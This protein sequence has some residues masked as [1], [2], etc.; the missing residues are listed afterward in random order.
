MAELASPWL[1]GWTAALAL[2]LTPTLF[3]LAALLERSGPIRL[4][5]WAQEAGGRLRALYRS[6]ARFTAFR[7]LL[8]LLAKLAPAALAVSVAVL[9]AGLGLS[10]GAALGWAVGVVALV[11][12]VAETMN[13]LLV[14]RDAEEALRR[15]TPFYRGAYALLTP[16]VAVLAPL[17]PAPALAT[18]GDDED[19]DDLSDEEIEAFIDFGTSEGILEPG[20]G[21]MV[22]GIV[23]FGDTPVRSV[24]TPRIDIICAPVDANLDELAQRFLDSGH[25]RL[26]LFEESI[27]K[28]V[29][30]L[31]IRE[32]L[33]GLRS[34]PRPL[35]RELAKEPFFVP[36]TKPLGDL[37]KEMQ[38]QF[39]Q[40]AV[41]LDE[42]GGT[43]GL[44]SLEDLIE[45]I[46][47][48]IVDDHEV[49][50]PEPEALP[51]GGWR[52]DGRTHVSTLDDLFAIDLEEEP[53]ETVGG[54]ILSAL[55]QVPEPGESVEIHG[56]RLTV[57]QVDNRRI[58][59]VQ[60]ERLAPVPGEVR[61]G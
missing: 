46:V 18:E 25:S 52:L 1:M 29:G 58:L 60:V 9:L 43:A 15:L 54:L 19:E 31:H 50:E 10:A 26:P 41:V 61:D 48:E 5:H 14:D 23:D 27:D 39:Q 12:A 20:E 40:M 35:A 38:G 22:W 33:R 24:M 6:P 59:A 57:E 32:L 53:Y 49:G 36:E 51:D 28:I 17:V 4:R 56:L 42:Y 44:V 3:A 21:E 7:Y 13:R 47:G 45:E 8:S 37:L 11:A 34:D 2:V 30:I 16:L 55:G